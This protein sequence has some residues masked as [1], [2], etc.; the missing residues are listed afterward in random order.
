[1]ILVTGASGFVGSAIVARLLRA[2]PGGVRAAV[3]RRSGNVQADLQYAL[4]GDLLPD[5]DWTS[6]LQKVGSIN[7]R[8]SSMHHARPPQIPAIPARQC[9]NVEF[10]PSGGIGG[11]WRSVISSVKVNGK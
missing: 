8:R 6:A 11:C 3:R 7:S 4:I 9:G 5:T 1:M 2:Y 10:G